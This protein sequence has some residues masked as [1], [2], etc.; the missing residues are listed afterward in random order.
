[1]AYKISKASFTRKKSH[2]TEKKKA[3]M[4]TVSQFFDHKLAGKGRHTRKWLSTHSGQETFSSPNF[5]D[6]FF[7]ENALTYLWFRLR[8]YA[9]NQSFIFLLHLSEFFLLSKVLIGETFMSYILMTHAT[10]L[11]PSAFWGLLEGQRSELNQSISKS[12]KNKIIRDWYNF[13]WLCFL[14]L[15]NI[16]IGLFFL[17]GSKLKT[18]EEIIFLLLGIVNLFELIPRS[19]YSAIFAQA[20]IYRPQGSILLLETLCFAINLVLYLHFRSSKALLFGLLLSKLFIVSTNW[21]YTS[22]AYHVHRLGIPRMSSFRFKIPVLPPG[23]FQANAWNHMFYMLM[24]RASSIFIILIL[25]QSKEGALPLVFHIIAPLITASTNWIQLFYFDFRK[26]RFSPFQLGLERYDQPLL[27]LSL[28]IGLLASTVAIFTLNALLSWQIRILYFPLLIFLCLRALANTRFFLKFDQIAFAF[29]FLYF[30][31]TLII[32]SGII[33]FGDYD[34]RGI[35]FLIA[36]AH[37]VALASSF[38]KSK[39]MLIQPRSSNIITLSQERYENLRSTKISNCGEFI[40]RIDMALISPLTFSEKLSALK[41]VFIAYVDRTGVFF[42]LTKEEDF[43]DKLA[44][45]SAGEVELFLKCR[46]EEWR[47]FFNLRCRKTSMSKSDIAEFEIYSADR[48]ISIRKRKFI[49]PVTESSKDRSAA[50]PGIR[51]FFEIEVDPGDVFRAVRR[52]LSS[53]RRVRLKS[54]NRESIYAKAAMDKDG[55]INNV[56]IELET[57]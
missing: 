31:I 56:K 49:E 50:I 11:I 8:F 46:P 21:H 17:S 53:G 52:S 30:F 39:K 33:Y 2:L 29:S 51:R 28:C 47:K 3:E 23:I 42:V 9:L 45:F 12:R 15:A 32:P 34:D 55:I 1:M 25:Y 26:F 38:F 10:T 57:K 40:G 6:A 41:G 20:R 54:V 4:S 43:A 24:Q 19:R 22:R 7:G 48:K 16:Y 44:R 35:L 27:M 36:T 18:I 5:T 37:L 13:A 14:A